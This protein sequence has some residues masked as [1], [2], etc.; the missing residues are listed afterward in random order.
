MDSNGSGVPE[1]SVR[2]NLISSG[3]HGTPEQQA[4]LLKAFVAFKLEAPPVIAATQK[5]E[6]ETK[7]GPGYDYSYADMADVFQIVVPILAKHGLALSQPFLLTSHGWVVRT[8]LYHEA[9]GYMLSEYPLPDPLQ[10]RPQSIGSFTTYAKRYSANAILGLAIEAEDDDGNKAEGAHDGERTAKTGRSDLPACPEC[11]K[12]QG[13]IRSRFADADFLCYGKKGGCGHKWF[14]ETDTTQPT[15][16]G[17]GTGTTPPPAEPKAAPAAAAAAPTQNGRSCP[18]CGKASAMK[19]YGSQMAC[20]P[21]EGGCGHTFAATRTL[22]TQETE[23]L[24]NAL[25]AAGY[26]TMGEIKPVILRIVPSAPLNSAG[27]P[28]LS[29][30]TTDQ[31]VAILDALAVMQDAKNAPPSG[32]EGEVPDEPPPADEA[33]S[34][35]QF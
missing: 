18:K 15:E 33:V 35:E 1:V 16:R 6:V 29:S 21:K 28:V 8:Y 3:V 25:R 4:A 7:S 10:D 34:E 22:N 13:V 2:L 9:G 24:R 31:Q 5:A 20:N 27:H 23:A 32:S 14:R 17:P 19:R 26:A 11:G 12:T 30:L